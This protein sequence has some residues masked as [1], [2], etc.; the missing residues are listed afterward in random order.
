[1]IKNLEAPSP[2]QTLHPI[3]VS[4]SAYREDGLCPEWSQSETPCRRTA[5]SLGTKRSSDA[6][7]SLQKGITMV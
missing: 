2:V 1:M 4:R 6:R 7:H 3:S 5:P